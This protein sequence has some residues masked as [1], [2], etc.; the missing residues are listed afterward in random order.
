VV[1]ESSQRLYREIVR[2]LRARFRTWGMA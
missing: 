2:D 1:S